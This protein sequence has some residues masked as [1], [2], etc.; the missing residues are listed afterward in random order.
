MPTVDVRQYDDYFV[1][2]FG[3]ELSRV[4]AYTL[5]RTLVSIS[6]A[7]KAASAVVNPGHDIE[8]VVE[9]LGRGSF[10]A[11]ARAVY[12]RA[13][14]LFSSENVKAVVLSIIASYIYEQVLAPSPGII[15][16]VGEDEI[17]IEQ[18]ET[19]I[20]V[21]REIHDTVSQVER[22]P[23][24]RQG[25]SDAFRALE[26]DQDIRNF[27]IWPDPN[28]P[29]PPVKIPRE[30]F[31]SAIQQLDPLQPDVRDRIETTDLQ[32]VRAILERSRRRWEFVWNG[33]RISAPV[34]DDHFYD[35]FFSNEITIA[36]GDVLK[37]RLRM[38]QRRDPN[39]SVFINDEYEVIEV[40]EHIPRSRQQSFSSSSG[41]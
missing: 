27:A 31:P 20:V 16:N 35:R 30:R 25:I 12:R 13:G 10:R 18:G 3:T 19:R 40:L 37:V 4:N 6:D 22:N 15:V 9:A 2:Y 41:E 33:V 24:F 34:L 7:A 8:I 14:N 21:P 26:A 17:V 1:I 23:R 28:E 38:K 36:P 29:D 5:A 11:T 32:I 39:L